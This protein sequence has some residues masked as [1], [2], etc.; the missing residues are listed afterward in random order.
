MLSLRAWIIFWLLSKFNT[1]CSIKIVLLHYCNKQY[2]E[3]PNI[4]FCLL[5][6]SWL[7]TFYLNTSPVVAHY[8]IPHD[9]T[10]LQRIFTFLLPEEWRPMSAILSACCRNTGKSCKYKPKQFCIK[11]RMRS[12]RFSTKWGCTIVNLRKWDFKISMKSVKIIDI[13][14]RQDW[15]RAVLLSRFELIKCW[16]SIDTLHI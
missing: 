8:T 3:F 4:L 11:R 13:E 1:D 9:N 10:Y 6:L 16:A 7:I 2:F 15:N 14:D 12:K 5:D